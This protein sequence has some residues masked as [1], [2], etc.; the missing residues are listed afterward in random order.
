MMRSRVD[1]PPPLGPSSAVSEPVGHLEGD[2]VE[3]DGVAEALGDRLDVDAHAAAFPCHVVAV[4]VGHG[5]DRRTIS[6]DRHRATAP[7]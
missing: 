2:V 4:A 3:R 5:E 1:L 7:T 6:A